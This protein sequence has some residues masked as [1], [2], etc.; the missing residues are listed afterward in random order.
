MQYAK[1]SGKNVVIRLPIDLLITAF[2]DN[3]NKYDEEIMVK[4]K[5]R[6]AEGFA[7]HI[8][9]HS[10]NGETGLTVFQEW[11]DSIFEEMI[12]SGAEYIKFPKEE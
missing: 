5:R 8:N 2:N 10:V 9:D 6:F 11:I 12:E 1:V 3:P 4:Y 7:E